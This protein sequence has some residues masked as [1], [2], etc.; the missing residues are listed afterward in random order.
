MRFLKLSRLA[1][2]TNLFAHLIRRDSHTIFANNSPRT[3]QVEESG[4]VSYWLKKL[5]YQ[6]EER[7][8]REKKEKN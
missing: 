4:K 6:Q 1:L 2:Y 8:E 7:N 3:P 5:F